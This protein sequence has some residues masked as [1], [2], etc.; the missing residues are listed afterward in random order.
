MGYYSVVKGSIRFSPAVTWKQVK[1]SGFVV[2]KEHQNYVDKDVMLETYGPASDDDDLIDT[3][4]PQ[5]EDSI[6]AYYITEH[7]QELVDL[8]G[9][10][11]NFEG[12]LQI[13]GEGHDDGNPD[14]WRLK[15]KDGKVVEIHPKL[16]WPEED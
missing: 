16:V 4:Y 7:L 1:D 13:E 9:S 14:I 6:K 10:D 5:S 8:L 3:I 2:N 15:V 12:Y 11:K